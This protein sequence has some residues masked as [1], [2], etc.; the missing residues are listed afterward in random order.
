MGYDGGDRRADEG[1]RAR[2]GWTPKVVRFR[3]IVIPSIIQGVDD[4]LQGKR[5]GGVDD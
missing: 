1:R 4:G 5:L 3:A 2:W